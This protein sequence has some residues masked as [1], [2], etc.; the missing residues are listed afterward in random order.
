MAAA[1]PSRDKTSLLAVVKESHVSRTRPYF[2]D[3][4]CFVS[5]N[6]GGTMLSVWEHFVSP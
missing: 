1:L 3:A 2:F 5:K 4:V 6:R